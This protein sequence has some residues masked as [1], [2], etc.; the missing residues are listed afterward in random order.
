MT[1]QQVF[2][3]HHGI[4][5]AGASLPVREHG[6]RVALKS[7]VNQLINAASVEYFGLRSRLGQNG[8]E[9]VLL[10]ILFEIEQHMSLIGCRNNRVVI[11][12]EL[13]GLQRP[14]AHGDLDAFSARGRAGGAVPGFSR[15]RPE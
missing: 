9:A 11:A 4:G 6:R 13:V 2:F 3:A 12:T 7:G 15:L 10:H 5:L 1:C 8:V 14:N